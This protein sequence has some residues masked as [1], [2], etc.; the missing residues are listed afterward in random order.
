MPC[1]RKGTKDNTP[2]HWV[3]RQ[4]SKV[5]ENDK[6]VVEVK[7]IGII[8]L[9]KEPYAAQTSGASPKQIADEAVH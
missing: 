7:R 6:V 8:E 1:S 4:L 2:L 5:Y 9:I 3:L